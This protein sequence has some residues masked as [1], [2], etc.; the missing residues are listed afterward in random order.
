[1]YGPS[2]KSNSKKQLILSH[3]VIQT[4]LIYSNLT[5]FSQKQIQVWFVI[6][7]YIIDYFYDFFRY[8]KK[9]CHSGI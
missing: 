6:D 9:K 3:Q 5:T 8:I 1:M 7:H 2:K 4:N